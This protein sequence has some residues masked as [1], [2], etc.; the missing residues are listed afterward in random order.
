MG[1]ILDI[2][3]VLIFI[4][5]IIITAKKGFLISVIGVVAF[6][7]S[8]FIAISVSAPVSEYVYKNFVREPVYNSAVT[9][10]E[11]ALGNAETSAAEK[12]DSFY[13]SLP[14]FVENFV[15]TEGLSSEE[16][17]ANFKGENLNA[18]AVADSLFNGVVDPALTTLINYIFVIL[19]AIVLSIIAKFLSK[20]ITKLIKGNIIGKTNAL[21]GAILGAVS[22][23]V[24]VICIYLAVSLLANNFNIVP[25]TEAIS[26]SYLCEL[27]SNII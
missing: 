5:S 26:T 11:T 16:I 8:L 18:T 22:G 15:K 10:L 21:L 4:L 19:F 25:L 9:T 13:D 14:D 6:A 2:V 12:L 20:A 17:V 23:A 24:I 7:L 1:I 27:I 3:L